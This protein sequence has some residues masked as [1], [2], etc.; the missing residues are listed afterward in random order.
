MAVDLREMTEDLGDPNNGEILSVDDGVAARFS[1]PLATHS[2][3]LEARESPP[4]SVDQLRA[5]H[6]PRC[7]SGRDKDSHTGILK[8]SARRPI[9]AVPGDASRWNGQNGTRVGNRGLVVC[10]HCWLGENRRHL[11]I[12][13]LQLI[14][15]V[16]DPALRE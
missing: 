2:E 5:V 12:F 16:V 10:T 6:F 1:H 7:F 4:K 11:L 3:K 13:I 15:L 14:Q 9:F 8:E